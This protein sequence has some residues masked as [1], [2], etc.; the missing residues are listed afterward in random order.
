[1]APNYD[2]NPIITKF[3]TIYLEETG[4]YTID[5]EYNR[6]T[7][8]GYRRSCDI[9]GTNSDDF[10]LAT[11]PEYKEPL[12]K[13]ICTFDWLGKG[14]VEI[15]ISRDFMENCKLVRV[16][17]SNESNICVS[18]LRSNQRDLGNVYKQEYFGPDSRC[19]MGSYHHTNI[20]L[21]DNPPFE[22][23]CQKSR[24]KKN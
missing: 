18:N 6:E 20:G 3:T 24:V 2:Q 11:L 21:S 14:L 16:Q 8:W 7:G 10:C 17:H 22:A 23:V 5:P 4:W 19:F 15:S 13:K 12:E 1:M 9:I